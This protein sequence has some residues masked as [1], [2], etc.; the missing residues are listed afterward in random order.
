MDINAAAGHPAHELAL[1]AAFEFFDADGNGSINAAEMAAAMKRLCVAVSAEEMEAIIAGADKDRDGEVSYE[2]FKQMSIAAS[3]VA[4]E[5]VRLAAAG[6]AQSELREAF[7]YFDTDGSGTIDRMELKVAMRRLGMNVGETELA[8]MIA[9]ADKDADG[10]IDFDEFR[11][12]CEASA[13]GAA[14]DFEALA[15]VIAEGGS[16]EREGAYIDLEQIVLAG[17]TTGEGWGSVRLRRDA[18]EAALIC[19][20]KLID[21]VLCADAAEKEVDA[22]EFCRVS[23]LMH[24]MVDLDP[25]RVSGAMHGPA[26]NM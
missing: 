10:Q 19:V 12:M 6:R 5:A 25:V 15:S 20:P 1:K 14:A 9:E 18:I 4:A 13:S 23:R 17:G 21:S 24:K 22:K 8:A 26:P 16:A 7:A 3:G 2:E 11:A